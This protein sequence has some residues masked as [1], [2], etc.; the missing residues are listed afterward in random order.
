MKILSF[1]VGALNLAMII[2][3]V[4]DEYLKTIP[5]IKNCTLDLINT[6]EIKILDWRVINLM[7]ELNDSHDCCHIETKTKKGVTS[8]T[9]CNKKGGFTVLDKYYCTRHSKVYSKILN[10][11]DTFKPHDVPCAKCCYNNCK[12]KKIDSTFELP[13]NISNISDGK[14]IHDNQSMSL[15]KSHVRIFKNLYEK[16]IK[17]KKIKKKNFV[18][19]QIDIIKLNLWFRL[20]EIKQLLDVDHVIIENQ[21]ALK[22][23]KM[24]T[25]SESLYNYFLCRGIVDKE[26]TG[27]TITM[28]KYINASNKLKL[29]ND[30]TEKIFKEQN[31]QNK[32]EKSKIAKKISIKYTKTIIANYP[33]MEIIYDKAKKKDDLGDCFL[34]G[35]YYIYINKI[36]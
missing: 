23:P 11:D 17:P 15:C 20:D 34:Q 12:I 18:N 16:K 19:T 32:T 10:F 27:S 4:D 5:E 13:E 24:K 3:D 31:P 36:I 2:L 6:D 7:D 14:I 9:K 26:R 28:I 29:D 35:L 33:D 25:M 30:N 22:N 21:L 8:H 1:D